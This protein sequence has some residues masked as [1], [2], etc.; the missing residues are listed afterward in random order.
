MHPLGFISQYKAERVLHNIQSVVFRLPEHASQSDLIKFL[1][2]HDIEATLGTY[3]LSATTYYS[4]KYN[5]IQPNA[6]WLQDHTITL[7]CY[8]DVDVTKVCDVIEKFMK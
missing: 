3:C 7:P 2:D 8:E 6:Q 5:N 1:S 4:K